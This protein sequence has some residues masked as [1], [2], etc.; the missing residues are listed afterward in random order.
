MR[1]LLISH[2]YPPETHGG[3]QGYVEE[4]AGLLLGG[5]HE[6]RVIA[7]ARIDAADGGEQ[8]A[9]QDGV[10]VHRLLRDQQLEQLSSDL[11]CDRLGRE[12]ERVVADFAPDLVHIHHWHALTRDLVRR[13]KR[14][15]YPVILSLHDLYTTCPL[16]FRMPDARSFCDSEVSLRQCAEC[17]AP[18][19]GGMD[20]AQLEG[21]LTERRQELLA[22][23]EAADRVLAV[24][25]PQADY[26]RSIPGFESL[27]LEV[28]GIGIHLDEEPLPA[29]PRAPDRLRIVNWG[30]IDPRKGIHLILE[31]LADLP[32]RE[33][34]EIHLHGR[35]GDPEYMEELREKG[36][37]LDLHF[38]GPFEEGE[39]RRFA[40][41][42]D[43]AVMPFLAFETYALAVDEAL[44]NGI[45]VVVSAHGAPPDRIGGRGLTFPCDDVRQLGVLLDR[46]LREPD[47]LGSL[48]RGTHTARDLRE[49]FSDLLTVY[50][51]CS[52]HDPTNEEV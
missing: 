28:M 35:E 29:T 13:M 31:A 32:G 45:P 12:V 10:R 5:G 20:V 27:D 4:L 17:V 39:P 44:R 46:M 26:L 25:R 11:G 19:V 30:G 15:G 9:E 40:A 51:Q 48:R 36:A 49:H 52:G 22:E 33:A 38:H 2:F 16:F 50:R 34:F 3:T 8:V 24:S 1:V 6:V 37:G 7:G 21:I 47:L 14:K 18:R 23:M 43:V 42:Y 41:E